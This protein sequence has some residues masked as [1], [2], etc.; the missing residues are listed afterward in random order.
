MPAPVRR[1]PENQEERPNAFKDIRELPW[2]QQ[3]L[4]IMGYVAASLVVVEFVV[5][6]FI[7][8]FSG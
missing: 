8:L 1:Q 3:W 2:W 5:R 6:W 4:E 7:F